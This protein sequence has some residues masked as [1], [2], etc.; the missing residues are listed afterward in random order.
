MIGEELKLRGYALIDIS[1]D[2][3]YHLQN[4]SYAND[5]TRGCRASSVNTNHDRCTSIIT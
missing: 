4:H 2:E 3:D 5:D 1:D